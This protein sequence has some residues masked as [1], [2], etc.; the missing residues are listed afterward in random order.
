MSIFKLL[1]TLIWLA[2]LI[3]WVVSAFGANK[4]VREQGW[5]RRS[6]YRLAILIVVVLFLRWGITNPEIFSLGH[7]GG[8]G[9]DPV[10]ERLGVIFCALGIGLAFWARAYLGRNWGMPMTLKENREL[11]T[12]GPY[13]FVRHPIYAGVLIAVFGSMLVE[14]FFWI[15]PFALYLAYFAYA[16]RREERMMLDEFPEAYASYKKHTRMLIPFVF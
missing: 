10:I 4:T 5:W 2:F 8:F 6:G 12:S 11:V 7:I 3:F 1:I 15:I 9:S 13:R 14:G 16:A